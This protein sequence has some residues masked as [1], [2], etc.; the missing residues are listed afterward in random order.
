MDGISS[1]SNN[2]KI[3][4]MNWIEKLIENVKVHNKCVLDTTEAGNT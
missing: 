1:T 2:N 3:C 4:E